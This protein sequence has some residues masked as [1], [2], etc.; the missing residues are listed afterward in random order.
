MNTNKTELATLGGGCF[1][2]T[3]ALY[4]ML[5]GVKS[6]VSGYAG[7][8]QPN[9][10][11]QE[12][13]SGRTGHAEVIQIEFDPAIL[14]YA[15]VLKTFWEAHD[16]TTLN[17]QG[18][19]VGTQYRSIILYHSDEQKAAAEKS[20]AEAQKQFKDPIVTQIAPL[21]KFWPAEDYHQQYYAR[22]PNAGYCRAV[23][24]PKV[25]K[26]QKKLKAEKN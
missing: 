13:C 26:F 5:P 3:E 7:G 18:A 9:P 20:K 10:T 16:P 22:N 11:Y 2:C 6:A 25:E 14:S 12:V 4:Q 24:R 23:I 8:E 19:D 1:W 17:R 15:K 21:T